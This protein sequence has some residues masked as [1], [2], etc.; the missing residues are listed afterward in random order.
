MTGGASALV[1]R[2]REE[3]KEISRTAERARFLTEKALAS[4]DDGFWDGVALNLHSFYTG[5][6][7]IL[8]EI[9]REVDG[10]LPTGPEWHRDLL[11]QMSAEIPGKRPAALSRETRLL[12]DEYQG[13]RHIVRNLYTFN[14]RP[15][16]LRNL[17]QHLPES[18]DLF[19]KDMEGFLAFLGGL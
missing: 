3:L 16:R 7:R 9:A 18:M 5:V 8:E 19:H 12:L 14:L 10:A 15:E 4:N 1:G 6:E 11:L 2:I 17:I 13:F